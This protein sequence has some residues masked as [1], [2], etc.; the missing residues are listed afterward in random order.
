M[1][2]TIENSILSKL[3]EVFKKF[4]IDSFPTDFENYTYTSPNGCILVRYESS[5]IENQTAL[6]AVNSNETYTFSIFISIRY[7]KKHSDCYDPLSKL[8]RTLNGLSIL[9]KRLVLSKR[10]FLDEINGDLWYGYS[11]SITLPITDEY[12][13]TSEANMEY[14]ININKEIF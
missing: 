12:P 2:K 7:A 8:K 9:H 10:E 14:K 5:N 13:D 4:E 6:T 3:K 1:I 11:V